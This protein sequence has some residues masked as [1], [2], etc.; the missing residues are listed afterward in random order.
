MMWWALTSLVAVSGLS[1]ML[2]STKVLGAGPLPPGPAVGAVAGS[3]SRVRVRPPTRT[4]AVALT[5]TLPAPDLVNSRVA[6]PLLSVVAVSGLLS[7]SALAS[8]YVMPA[9]APV[10]TKTPVSPA[11]ATRPV[12]GSSLTVAVT[13]WWALTSLVAVSGLSTMLASTTVL[14]AGPL[15]PGP[16]V[17]AVA[18]SV[19][20][21]RVRPPT[22]TVA[23]AL[24]VTLPAPALV[25]SRVAWPLLSVV[26]VSGLLSPSAFASIYALSLHDALPI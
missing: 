17:G 14:R 6:R 11:A 25:N 19:S 26:A 16:A 23:V 24:T 10:T 9:V 2:A 13:M 21:V 22:R 20:R 1:T 12:P 18:G 5:V 8:K 15:P 3:V 7:P 4:V